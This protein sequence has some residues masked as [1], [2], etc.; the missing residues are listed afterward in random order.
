MTRLIIGLA[1]FLGVHSISIFAN[2]WRDRMVARLGEKT[3]KALYGLASIVGFVLLVKGYGLAR[4][5]PVFLYEPRY[6]MRHL[7]ALLMLPV[8]P[9]LLAVYLPGRI[10]AANSTPDRT[11]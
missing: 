10:S 5:D 7:T 8:F 1:I 9:L 4:Q 2:D 3:W 11:G 6:F